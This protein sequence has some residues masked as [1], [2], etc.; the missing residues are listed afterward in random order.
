MAYTDIPAIAGGGII[1][2]DILDT[3]ANNDSYL[4]THIPYMSMQTTNGEYNNGSPEDLA[5][6]MVLQGGTFLAG[7]FTGVSPPITI[8]L[9]H[10]HTGKGLPIVTATCMVGAT[11]PEA[12]ICSLTNV[13][14]TNF[15][16]KIHMTPYNATKTYSNPRIFWTAI[17]IAGTAPC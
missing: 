4:Y 3:L 9:F 6:K 14:A 12:G 13:T 2:Y 15:T 1:D 10:Q 8:S 7:T 17:T 5:Y 16:M 11:L